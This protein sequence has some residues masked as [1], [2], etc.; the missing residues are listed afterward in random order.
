MHV[1]PY[2][3][4]TSELDNYNMTNLNFTWN[5]TSFVENSLIL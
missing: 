4:W 5:A 3:D 1:N 2:N